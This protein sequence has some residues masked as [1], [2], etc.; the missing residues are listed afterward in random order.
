MRKQK[1][2]AIP[3]GFVAFPHTVL[4]H[5]NFWSLSGNAIKLLAMLMAQYRGRNNGDL[6][7]GWT[8]A[9]RRGWKSQDTLHRAKAELLEKGF[10]AETRKGSFPNTCS[11]YGI[12]WLSLDPD[13]K[14][15]IQP[16]GFP[17]GAWNRNYPI[18]IKHGDALNTKSVQG[19]PRINT[20]AVSGNLQ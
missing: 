6:Q 18:A 12:T 1:Q 16:A 11:L 17:V 5:P 2:N 19:K 9:Q 7:A 8:Y 13:P 15:H 14:F 20:P 10:I 4:N 3:G